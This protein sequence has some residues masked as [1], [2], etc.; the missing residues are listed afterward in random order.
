[1][2]GNLKENFNEEDHEEGKDKDKDKDKESKDG[3]TEDRGQ[4]G[5]IHS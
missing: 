1:M 2:V 5:K 4:K 3:Q